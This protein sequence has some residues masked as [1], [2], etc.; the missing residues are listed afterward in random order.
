VLVKDHGPSLTSNPNPSGRSPYFAVESLSLSNPTS[1]R[2]SNPHPPRSPSGASTHTATPTC[3][4]RA[5]SPVRRGRTSTPWVGCSGSRWV[6]REANTYTYTYAGLIRAELQTPTPY[7]AVQRFPADPIAGTTASAVSHSRS[8]S[9]SARSAGCRR[10]C[11]GFHRGPGTRHQARSS[12]RCSYGGTT[13]RTCTR[14]T[15][16]V[17]ARPSDFVREHRQHRAS[18]ASQWPDVVIV[19]AISLCRECLTPRTMIPRT[20]YRR[21]LAS[22]HRRIP[23]S[24]HPCIHLGCTSVN[25]L[26]Y[27]RCNLGAMLV[28]KLV[29]ALCSSSYSYSPSSPDLCL[30]PWQ[31]LPLVRS[32]DK[33]RHAARHAEPV[34]QR[35][36]KRPSP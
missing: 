6:K 16:L 26:F 7:R 17:T 29:L 1:H 14:R 34:E 35:A 9:K 15:G 12:C 20:T 24:S 2:Q 3:T 27:V 32:L 22:S 8:Y 5:P 31:L 28:P 13:R 11:F 21:L 30:S 19:I 18:A 33:Q 25:L 10:A 4:P 23:A 36:E